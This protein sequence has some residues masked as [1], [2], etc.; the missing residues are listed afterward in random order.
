[1]IALALRVG[2]ALAGLWIEKRVGV[3]V[4]RIRAQLLPL[5]D[6]M[7]NADVEINLL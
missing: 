5:L 1:L 4:K 7:R 3:G 2:N 6:V